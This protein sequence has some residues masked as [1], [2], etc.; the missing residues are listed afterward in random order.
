MALGDRVEDEQ[1]GGHLPAGP[2]HA[3][4]KLQGQQVPEVL[5]DEPERRGGRDRQP[6]D[7]EQPPRSLFLRESPDKRQEDD[8]REHGARVDAHQL[9]VAESQV[10]E[11]VGG[12]ERSRDLHAHGHREHVEQNEPSL[13]PGE[14]RL[15]RLAGDRLDAIDEALRGVAV[16]I[17][18][19]R[20]DQP[21]EERDEEDQAERL[22]LEVAA[23]PPL[24]HAR[25]QREPDDE[26]H[27]RQAG[28]HREEPCPHRPRHERRDPGVPRRRGRKP[29][30]PVDRGKGEDRP[31]RHRLDLGHHDERQQR[32]RLDAGVR[33]DPRAEASASADAPRRDHLHR[34]TDQERHR[35]E[36]SRGHFTEARREPEGD[37]VRL[38]AAGHHR[39]R[40]GVGVQQAQI[41]PQRGAAGPQAGRCALG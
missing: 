9:Q 1:E 20:R 26:A 12:E 30:R 25:R 11:D 31:H 8:L 34:G 40:E 19:D 36:Q 37:E 10:L 21:R 27:L 6:A 17:E 41:A 18:Q 38:A 35:R 29:A 14:E 32:E 39:P 4:G 15:Q 22:Q 2:S 28:T 3:D 5:R 24:Q 23:A 13:A 33:G 16:S 7:P